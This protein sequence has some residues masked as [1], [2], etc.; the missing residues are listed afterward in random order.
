MHRRTPASS[1]DEG[2]RPR[3]GLVRSANASPGQATGQNSLPEVRGDIQGVNCVDTLRWVI[4]LLFWP[5]AQGRRGVQMAIPS[6][7]LEDL[8]AFLGGERHF[9][10]RL[11]LVEGP[12]P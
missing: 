8:R 1:R 6:Q 10:E 11:H 5:S 2:S 4:F 12:D 7:V 3:T 9:L